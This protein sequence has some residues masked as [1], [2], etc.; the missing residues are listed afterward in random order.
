[1]YGH[2]EALLDDPA[3]DVVHVAT[4]NHLHYAITSAA[5]ARGKHVVSEKPLATTAAEAAALLESASRAGIVHAVMFN[6]RGNPLVQ[7]ARHLVARGDIGV[8]HLLHGHY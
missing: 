7:E 4:P 2:Y 3:V 5:I 8:P 6:Y 1:S